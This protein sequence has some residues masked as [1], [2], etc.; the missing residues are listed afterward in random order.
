MPTDDFKSRI[1][2]VLSASQPHPG[3][4]AAA[5]IVGEVATALEES[6]IVPS[7][8][9]T[10]EPGPLLG[11]GQQLNVVITIARTAFRSVL[12]R[13]YVPREG[14]P[15]SLDLFGEE[16]VRCA[17]ADALEDALLGFVRDQDVAARLR[18]IG[19]AQR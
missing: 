19:S 11:L 4:E 6:G 14:F 1:K 13:A 7:A 10:I 2:D 3:Y 17:D 16:I 8:R 9:T 15:V 5:R 12:F 18:M